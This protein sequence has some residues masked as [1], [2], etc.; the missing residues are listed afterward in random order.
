MASGRP[1]EALVIP[2]C[3]QPVSSSCSDLS[4]VELPDEIDEDT[5]VTVSVHWI[6]IHIPFQYPEK[7]L[8]L[9]VTPGE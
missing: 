9:R 8:K 2:E 7:F 6:R 4:S 5:A 3:P 1:T